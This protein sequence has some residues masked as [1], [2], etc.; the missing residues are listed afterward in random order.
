[1]TQARKARSARAPGDAEALHAAIQGL[2]RLADLFAQR[3]E[4]LAREIGLSVPQWRVLEEIAADAF[5][6]SL[7]AQK[8][9]CTPAAV[10]KLVR[11]LVERGLVA[12]SIS[13]ADAR[14]RDYRLTARGRKLLARV[15]ASRERAIREV[16]SDLDRREL[17][18]F[19][20]FSEMLGDRLE[21]YASGAAGARGTTS[22]VS[23][24]S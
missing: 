16:W 9:A 6:P 12:V 13:G 20:R 5:M 21:R 4:Q 18:R 2:Q 8:R 11:P 10:S 17:A 3:R 19:A 1:M 15:R 24:T 7:F 23:K 22:A 14:Q